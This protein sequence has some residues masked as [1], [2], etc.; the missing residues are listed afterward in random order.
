M[1][2][3]IYMTPADLRR[4][5]AVREVRSLGPAGVSYRQ[6]RATFG[7]RVVVPDAQSPKA[8][9]RYNHAERQVYFSAFHLA[10]RWIPRYLEALRRHDVRWVTGYSHSIY[11][12]AE[13]ALR[14]G[15][16]PGRDIPELDAVITA[17][18][19]VSREMREVLE[20]AFQTRVFEEYGS[21]ENTFVASENEHHQML[22]SPDYGIF[23]TVD[24]EGRP[25]PSD[26]PG[27]VLTTGFAVEGQ[28]LV[29]FRLG[30]VA[31][32]SGE[33]PRCGRSMPVV[34]DVVGRIEE[35]VYAPDGRRTMRFN[36]IF[37][38]QPN[39]RAGQVVQWQPDRLTV[40]VIPTPEF[41]PA[42]AHD[43]EREVHQR[44]GN[45]V[46]VEVTTVDDLERS[47]SGKLRAVI[48]HLSAEEISRLDAG[49]AADPEPKP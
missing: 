38:A 4:G 17:S 35:V 6:A 12:L 18:E 49:A 16:E 7:V 8:V 14:A 21:V 42:D 44:L 20:K 29:R 26:H 41:G 48:S 15:L 13:L 27:E 36:G 28:P 37:V 31:T 23:E 30:D 40:R 33:L 47:P 3:G 19:P 22:L 11:L 2:L 1:P 34:R 24:S 39:V 32:L 10:P 45:R 9:H 25:V 5:M 46:A 43:L